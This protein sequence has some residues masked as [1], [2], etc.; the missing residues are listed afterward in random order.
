MLVFIFGNHTIICTPW[1][2]IFLCLKK[3]FNT[4]LFFAKTISFQY[5]GG[6]SANELLITLD[7]VVHNLFLLTTLSNYQSL[8]SRPMNL[9][10]RFSETKNSLF[11]NGRW[12]AYFKFKF[13]ALALA[14]IYSNIVILLKHGLIRQELKTLSGFLQNNWQLKEVLLS[15]FWKF[16]KA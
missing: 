6:Y 1:W 7:L 9:K 3:D 8:G 5:F 16:S 13:N 2:C 12:L 15:L 10:L 11:L 4:E 14:K